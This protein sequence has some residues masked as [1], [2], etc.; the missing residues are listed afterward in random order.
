MLPEWGE[1]IVSPTA[2][3]DP[4]GEAYTR[5]NAE[6]WQAL[7]SEGCLYGWHLSSAEHLALDLLS[8]A[9]HTQTNAKE[10]LLTPGAPETRR[11]ARRP[12]D[13]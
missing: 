1:R 2:P 13:A 12:S 6:G 3:E 5:L 9:D 7:L 11:Y 8:S 4:I 10:L